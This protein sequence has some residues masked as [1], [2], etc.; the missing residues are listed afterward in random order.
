MAQR[1]VAVSNRVRKTCVSSA[2]TALLAGDRLVVPLNSSHVGSLEKG[3]QP[4]HPL[5]APSHHRLSPSMRFAH[6]PARRGAAGS[7]AR[8]WPG[9]GGAVGSGSPTGGTIAGVG[10]GA[11]AALPT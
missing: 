2:I 8:G 3:A 11:G 9:G 4:Q 5:D 1:P 7:G 6:Q 10:W